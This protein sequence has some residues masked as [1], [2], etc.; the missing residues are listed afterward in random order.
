MNHLKKVIAILTAITG[1][2]TL[3]TGVIS[4]SAVDL[5]AINEKILNDT[6]TAEE[7]LI[8]EYAVDE[9]SAK[10]AEYIADCVG[11]ISL[12]DAELLMMTYADGAKNASDI[13]DFSQIG[14]YNG[15]NLAPTQHY[16]I[17]IF[18]GTDSIYDNTVR[19]KLDTTMSIYGGTYTIFDDFSD[20]IDDISCGY[21]KN[22][23]TFKINLVSKPASESLYK[24][25]EFPFSY[26]NL[27]AN[28]AYGM[29]TFSFDQTGHF[30]HASYAIGDVDHNGTVDSTDTMYI[31]KYLAMSTDL[32]FQYSNCSA[33]ISGIVN[34]EAAD[35]NEDSSIDVADVISLNKY[36]ANN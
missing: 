24:I 12:D 21:A 13:G 3:G 30:T 15:D 29:S 14:Y 27:V 8:A 19:I 31:L 32:A 10:V 28:E 36:L 26:T 7:K 22:I 35:F 33:G 4:A 18:N 9:D 16:F 5:D 25:S 17:S 20:Y 2:T 1:M 6:A 23:S 34:R 11:E